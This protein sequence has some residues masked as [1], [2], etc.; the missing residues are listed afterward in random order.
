MDIRSPRFS[1]VR[2]T[3]DNYD[4]CSDTTVD[5]CLPV[6]AAGD[7]AFQFIVQGT[8]MEVSQLCDSDNDLVTVGLVEEC[9]AADENFD[10]NF[11]TASSLKPDRVKISET[12][13][14]YMWPHGFPG[15]TGV[16]NKGDCFRIKVVVDHPTEGLIVA[17][18]NCFERIGQD[19][20][21]SVLEYGAAENQFGFNYCGGGGLFEDEETEV[22][23]EPTIVQ[24]TNVST[25]DIPYTTGMQSSYGDVPTVE[26][27]MLDG[28][29]YVNSIIRAGFD[30]YPP[31][32]IIADLGG[33]ATGFV[34]IS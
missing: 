25:L 23:A 2:F 22:C 20:F 32:R 13:V 27:W 14:L 8:Q 16:Y 21:T 11:K 3:T 6:Y 7:I 34:K 31:T 17:C 28:T 24:F 10:L 1:F 4:T 15:F 33:P 30:A 9:Y 5:F 26:I 18:S 12:E 29:E 19:C